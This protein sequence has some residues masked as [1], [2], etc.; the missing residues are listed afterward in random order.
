MTEVIVAKQ[1]NVSTN[2]KKTKARIT[3]ARKVSAVG[4]A[5]RSEEECRKKFGNL[6]SSTNAKAARLAKSKKT[7]DD[8]RLSSKSPLKSRS[9]IWL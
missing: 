7:T 2:E 5:M 9:F 6:Q 1:R 8:W 3:I 4:V